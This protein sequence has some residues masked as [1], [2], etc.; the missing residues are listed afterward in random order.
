[1]LLAGRVDQLRAGVQKGSLHDNALVERHYCC[2]HFWKPESG[3]GNQHR[4]DE[5][6]SARA[7]NAAVRTRTDCPFVF[8]R[9]V[10][11]PK[12]GQHTPAIPASGFDA[13]SAGGTSSKKD[14]NSLP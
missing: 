2:E 4:R 1:A 8:D 5:V 12:S 7:V 14:R 6:L 9:I 3:S 10:F 13:R 11:S